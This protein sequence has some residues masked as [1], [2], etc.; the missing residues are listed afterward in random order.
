MPKLFISVSRKSK[1]SNPRSMFLSAFMSELASNSSIA[2]AFAGKDREEF[3]KGMSKLT[4]RLAEK[5]PNSGK[6]KE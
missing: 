3:E 4:K 5:M 1:K 2:E 6:S